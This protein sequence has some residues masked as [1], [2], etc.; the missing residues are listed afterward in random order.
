MRSSRIIPCLV[1][2]AVVVIAPPSAQAQKDSRFVFTPYVGVYAPST[3]VFRYRLVE[4]GTAVSFN[5]RHQPAVGV[6][7]SASVWLDD[8]FAIEAGGLYSRNT[9]RADLFMN[10][11]GPLPRT[12]GTAKLF[13]DVTSDKH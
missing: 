1:L 4:N 2:T 3:D 5:T 8:R 6:G 12:L 11:I 9:L 10:Q 7:V 13:N